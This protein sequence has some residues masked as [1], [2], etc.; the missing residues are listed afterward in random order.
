MKELIGLLPL[1]KFDVRDFD[2]RGVPD[3]GGPVWHTSETV[4]WL[5]VGAENAEKG[6]STVICG[7]NE[8][9]RVRAARAVTHPEVELILLHASGDVIR[10]RLRGRYPSPES[11]KE[12]E[13]MAGVPLETFIENCVSYAPTLRNVFEKEHCYII[14]SDA[15]TP[16]QVATEVAEMLQTE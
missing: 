8:P 16:Q 4:H 6:K 1:E 11:E 12:I 14:D 10:E 2:E 13:R 9:E 5:D 7:F 3:G 15:K